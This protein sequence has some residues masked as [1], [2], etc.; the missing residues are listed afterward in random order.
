MAQLG[1]EAS[2]L[3]SIIR[4]VRSQLDVSLRRLLQ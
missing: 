2:E 4:L 3:D 1:I